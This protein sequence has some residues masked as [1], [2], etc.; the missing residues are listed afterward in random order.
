MKYATRFQW[1]A[2]FAALLSVLSLSNSVSAQNVADNVRPV[3]SVCLAGQPCV[4]TLA[5]MASVS[6]FAAVEETTGIEEERF[7]RTLNLI[8]RVPIGERQKRRPIESVLHI[9]SLIHI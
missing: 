1:V 2:V 5:S 8:E 7:G 9:L 6:D 3:G 4:G